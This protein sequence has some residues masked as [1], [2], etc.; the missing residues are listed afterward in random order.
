V[1]CGTNQVT[2]EQIKVQFKGGAG[3]KPK[4]R[5]TSI[6]RALAEQRGDVVR[7]PLGKR[8][9]PE[10]EPT[11]DGGK[12]VSPAAAIAAENAATGEPGP[13][14]KDCGFCGEQVKFAAIKCKHCG[15]MIDDKSLKKALSGSTKRSAVGRL[16]GQIAPKRARFKPARLPRKPGDPEQEEPEDDEAEEDEEAEDAAEAAESD[17]DADGSA[18]TLGDAD[19]AA[20]LT[21]EEES[22][23][24]DENAEKRTKLRPRSGSPLRRSGLLR[25]GMRRGRRLGGKKP[26][27]GGDSAD[28]DEAAEGSDDDEEG[29]LIPDEEDVKKQDARR[30]SNDASLVDDIVGMETSDSEPE[31]SDTSNGG[32]GNGG[33]QPPKKRISIRKRRP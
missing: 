28:S 10:E 12:R 24:E 19:P 27:G 4:K 21:P 31:P 30:A 29:E 18:A 11:E 13:E 9:E 6:G 1:A 16:R 8:A 23:G 20:D 33:G 26:L 15:E 17:E 3:A 2:G 22:E 14:F 32:T 5:M 25:P 7:K